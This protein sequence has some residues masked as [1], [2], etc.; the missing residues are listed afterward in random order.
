M[1]E[2]KNIDRGSAAWGLALLVLLSTTA[3]CKSIWQITRE[4]KLGGDHAEWVELKVRGLNKSDAVH[5]VAAHQPGAVRDELR[6]PGSSGTVLV[7]QGD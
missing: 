4:F 6:E 1:I 2:A 3:G 7:R 5:I